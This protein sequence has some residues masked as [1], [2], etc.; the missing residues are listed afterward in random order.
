[1]ESR[2][3]ELKI[4]EFLKLISENKGIIYKICNVYAN[5]RED[6]KDLKQEIILQLWKSFPGFLGKSKFIFYL[7]IDF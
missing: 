5:N 2:K 1:M 7:N 6:K 3:K 4:N